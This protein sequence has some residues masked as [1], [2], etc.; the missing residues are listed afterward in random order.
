MKDPRRI[1]VCSLG[2]VFV[3]LLCVSG[4]L[5]QDYCITNPMNASCADYQPNKNTITAANNDL[6]GMMPMTQCTINSLCQQYKYSGDYCEPF[7]I[8]KSICMD[9]SDMSGCSTYNTMCIPGSLVQICNIPT[10]P[11]PS[12]SI[13]KANISQICAHMDMVPCSE[14]TGS[15]S[16]CD[17]LKVYSQLCLSMP[18]MSECVYWKTMCDDIPDW[19]LCTASKNNPTPSMQMYFHWSIMDYVLLQ[20][21]VPDSNTTYALTWLAVFLL[22]TLFEFVKLV[23]S[24]YEKKWSEQEYTSLN[25]AIVFSGAPFRASVDI[26]RA[27]LHTLE[28]AWGFLVMLVV[29]TYNIGLFGAVLAGAFFGMLVVGR[30][31]QYVPKA[32]CH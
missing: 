21:W 23:R 8:Y 30:F 28:V 7:S 10:L 14:C 13:L 9:M 6:C 31:V 27:L 2:S 17:Y 3:L 15:S 16:S 29:M 22:A 25:D 4:I 1:Q 20:S 32:G 18:D 24:K 12:A 11:L 5:A 19:T 26:P